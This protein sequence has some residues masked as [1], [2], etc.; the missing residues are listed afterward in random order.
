MPKRKYT[1]PPEQQ[2][3]LPLQEQQQEPPPKKLLDSLTWRW[4]CFGGTS[5]DL[6]EW[7]VYTAQWAGD[8][9]VLYSPSA[10][11]WWWTWNRWTTTRAWSGWYQGR[12]TQRP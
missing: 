2:E 5:S 11:Y 9:G 8:D 12:G 6:W 4:A 3:E 10:W 7:A 1:A